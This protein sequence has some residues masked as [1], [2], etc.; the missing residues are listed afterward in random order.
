MGPAKSPPASLSLLVILYVHIAMHGWHAFCMNKKQ[1]RL[2]PLNRFSL[3]EFL[4]LISCIWFLRT[5]AIAVMR[6]CCSMCYETTW[7]FSESIRINYIELV[8]SSHHIRQLMTEWM[9][10]D[11]TFKAISMLMANNR[12]YDYCTVSMS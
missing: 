8:L 6:H 12:L 9:F 11:Q 2:K 10:K 1:F 7:S 5:S 3:S 4:H